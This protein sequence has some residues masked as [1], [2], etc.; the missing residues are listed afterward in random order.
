MTFFRTKSS[1]FHWAFR[2]RKDA[3]FLVVTLLIEAFAL[4]PGVAKDSECPPPDANGEFCSYTYSLTTN[5]DE[6][7]CPRVG[8]I[9][10]QSFR[11]PFDYRSAA[12]LG[13]KRSKLTVPAPVIYPASKE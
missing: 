12:P 13:T 8:T 7:I 10:R 5:E 2:L 1:H 3:A 9:L 4:T 11:R 6:Q